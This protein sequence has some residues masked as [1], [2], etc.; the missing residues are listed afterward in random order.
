MSRRRGKAARILPVRPLLVCGLLAGWLLACAAPGAASTSAVHPAH[1]KPTAHQKR[2]PK[3]KW[4]VR[5]HRHHKCVSRH[6]SHPSVPAAPGTTLVS[7]APAPSLGASPGATGVS[8]QPESQA[9]EAE[10]PAGGREPPVLAHVQVSAR[11][12]GYTLSRSTV[13]AG[14]VV[15]QF[16]NN[17]EDEHNLNVNSAEG[18]REGSFPNT[19]SKGIVNQAIML[20]AGSYTL[21]CTLPEHEKKGMKATLTVE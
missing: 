3:G 15:F 9:P 2:C 1:T 18:S 5:V 14:K 10:A 4:Y 13:P 6:K 7:A 8:V 19:P 12:Y 11:E 16:V 17:G 21:F 20:K